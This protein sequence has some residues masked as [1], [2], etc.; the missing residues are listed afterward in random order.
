MWLIVAAVAVTAA[1]G[2]GIGIAATGLPEVRPAAS[3]GG[4][5]AGGSQAPTPSGA[6]ATALVRLG[7]NA[8]GSPSAPDV[9]A[10]LDRHFT[11]INERDFDMWT[12]TV[13]TTRSS[14]QSADQW[15]Q[16]YRSTVDSNV[17]VTAIRP[18]A[19]GLLVSVEFQSRQ[20][21]VDAP[22]DLQVGNICWSS[23]WPLA[24]DGASLRIGTPAKGATDKRQC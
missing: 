6:G 14:S 4:S 23:R 20:N 2:A 22:A 8:A 21:P 24:G 16:V 9:L 5:E 7:A 12:T 19:N 10:L 1:T 13:T 18:T 17:V 3:P 15:R 11:A